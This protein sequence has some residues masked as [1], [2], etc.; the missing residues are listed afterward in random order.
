MKIREI[1][2]LGS[3]NPNIKSGSYNI[4][5]MDEEENKELLSKKVYGTSVNQILL[6]GLMEALSQCSNDSE[7]VVHTN[8]SLG[9]K[10]A[11]KSVNKDILKEIFKVCELRNIKIIMQ[12]KEDLSFLK[13]IVRSY[14]L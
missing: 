3:C 4:I 9:W 1:F 13:D 6:K 11:K 12:E 8:T 7:V 2:M 10:N 5:L 14:S